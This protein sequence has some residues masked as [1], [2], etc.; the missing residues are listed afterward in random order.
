MLSLIT[1]PSSK[2]IEEKVNFFADFFKL[3]NS[4]LGKYSYLEYEDILSIIEKVTFQIKNNPENR[5][6]YL[7]HH[8]KHSFLKEK[9]FTHEFKYFI[10]VEPLIED[11]LSTP[12]SVQNNWLERNPNFLKLLEKLST[13]L[14]NKQFEIALNYLIQFLTCQHDLNEHSS[15]FI[16]LVKIMISELRFSERPPKEIKGLIRRIMSKSKREFPLPEKLVKKQNDKNFNKLVEDF[17]ANRSFREQFEG[18]INYRN[19]N[20]KKGFYLFKIYRL[21]I[22]KEEV[23]KYDK[24]EIRS[25][26]N[27]IFNSLKNNSRW[28]DF[29]NESNISIALVTADLNKNEEE[30][31]KGI[32]YVQRLIRYL[33]NELEI[34]SYLE[35]Y[36]NL[37]TINFIDVG[38]RFS[39][40]KGSKI[41]EDEN[42]SKLNKNN[43]YLLLKENNSEAAIKFLSAEK[44][45]HRALTTKSVSDFWHYLECLIPLKIQHNKYTKQIKGVCSHI[46]VLDYYNTF[47]E[48]I[49]TSLINLLLTD[50]L[51][52]NAKKTISRTKINALIS[53]FKPSEI[54][55]EAK[56]H[57]H[58]PIVR[59]LLKLYAHRKSI[60][61]CK[62]E[63]S[64]YY[65]I[66]HEVYEFRNS[67]IHGGIISKYAE[68]K[69]TLILPNLIIKIRK[70]ILKEI[71]RYKKVNMEKLVNNIVK[72]TK[73]NC[74]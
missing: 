44:Y 48:H 51:N 15:H 21:E 57:Q 53:N 49:G 55:K 45:Y 29:V 66:L 46:L 67:Y 54:V 56:K 20:E 7:K 60:D 50:S 19:Y 32:L 2:L 8:L 23:I 64:Y 5:T 52:E 69:L 33:N 18:L 10:K 72:K 70:V 47:S 37:N 59:E 39:F 58:H 34:N 13:E 17:F 42:L 12:N 1:F 25:P 31:K 24:V 9:W 27:K 43:P 30:R 41:L 63:L 71:I 22:S 65:S 61:S 3:L 40:D 36:S 35:F 26:E 11:F 6:R 62:K 4:Y 73:E 68:K 28:T 74:L 16:F 14:Q 38:Y